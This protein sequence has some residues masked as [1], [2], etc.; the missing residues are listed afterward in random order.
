VG[1][2]IADRVTGALSSATSTFFSGDFLTII[3][4][5]L[6]VG[7][8]VAVFLPTIG[9]ALGAVLLTAFSGGAIGAG[10]YAAFKDPKIM[11]AGKD[12]MKDFGKLFAGFGE[13][14]KPAVGTFFKG[15]GDVLKQI[16]PLVKELGA[17]LG[18]VA[19]KLGQGVVGMLQNLLPAVLRFAEAGAPLVETLADEL[20]GIGDALGDMFDA[21]A[22]E[23]P[24]MNNFWNDFLNV[25]QLVIRTV[26]HLIAN[27]AAMYDFARTVFKGLIKVV[28]DVFGAI[29]AGAETAFS[30]M[31]GIGGKLTRARKQFAEFKAGVNRELN[32]ID[33]VD[34]TVRIRQ[35]FSVVGNAVADVGAILARRAAGGISGAASGG[36]R[37]NLTWVGEHGPELVQLPAGSSV[38]SN[39]DSMRMAAGQGGGLAPLLVQLVLDGRVIAERLLDPQRELVSQRFG[40]NVQ[41]AYGRGY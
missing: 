8:L 23:A 24:A 29:L 7:A 26:G 35:V 4:K 31:P 13:F 18:P 38:K 22:E 40:G 28:L 27:F 2:G 20:P 1:K 16:T 17:K 36:I 25:L 21:I 30:W 34:V 37:S 15:M 9:A 11:A 12:L 10:I 33:D 32:G 6:T 19:E 39:P 5:T 41:A 14:F 3:L